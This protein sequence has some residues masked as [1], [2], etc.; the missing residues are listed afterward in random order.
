MKLHTFNPTRDRHT[1]KISV[2]LPVF[3]ETA[4]LH[5]L[6]RRIVK[7]LE[8]TATQFEV[9]Y[10]NDGSSDGSRECLSDLASKDRRVVVVHLSRNF[11]HQPAVH[12]GLDHASGD[13][14]IVMDSDLQDDPNAIP[15]FLD[16]WENGFDVV[17]AQRTNRKES[18]VK[19]AM[20]Y[21]F[22]RVLN[23]IA[24]SPIPAD[25]GNFG[26]L[27]RS[28]VDAVLSLPERERFFP[29]LRS[30][31][32]FRQIGIPVERAARHDDTPRVSLR[33]L[34]RLAKTAIF[35]FS[36]FPLKFFYVI[37]S[38]SAAVCVGTIGFVLWHKMF[39]RLA[40]P[41]W[42]SVIITASFFGSLNALG[43]SILGEYVIRIYDQV[44]ARPV[45]VKSQLLNAASCRQ[46][47]SPQKSHSPIDDLNHIEEL[48]SALQ[49]EHA[50]S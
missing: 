19:R 34:F 28:V 9:V 10:V 26:L 31:A 37:A 24:D 22:Y 39:T 13:V 43:I 38:I 21:S 40:I 50:T 36:S 44:R 25:A 35:S 47:N 7:V 42:A 46:P 2:V 11:G 16:Q 8:A 45:Y 4:I 27:D 48:L 30:W 5:E 23:A 20:F 12:A 1:A 14:V 17:Y 3:N 32:G 6:N 15:A 29:G 33:G 49:K 41:G 18:L